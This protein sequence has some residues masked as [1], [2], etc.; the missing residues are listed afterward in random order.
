[1]DSLAILCRKWGL[2]LEGRLTS[3][4][5][6]VYKARRGDSLYILKWHRQ[7]GA[8]REFSILTK[9][10]RQ[11]LQVPKPL[12]LWPGRAILMAYIPG[13]NLCDLI[14]KRP[15]PAAALKL[16]EWYAAFHLAFTTQGKVLLKG[17]SILRNFIWQEGTIW[18][19]DFEESRPGRPAE[20]IGEI[21]CSILTTDPTFTREKMGLSRLLVD[22]YQRLAPLEGVED[23]LAW[24]L[25]ET[26]RRRGEPSLLTKARLVEKMGLDALAED[27]S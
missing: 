13:E 21:I 12:D 1:M 11:G 20:D 8:D 18:G 17:D 23:A 7:E 27:P 2:S 9:A 25:R 10:H 16:A 26:A 19:V 15:S 4:K 5:N 22:H 3:K 14:S 6:L 24:A